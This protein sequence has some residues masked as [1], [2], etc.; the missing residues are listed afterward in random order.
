MKGSIVSNDVAS[1]YPFFNIAGIGKVGESGVDFG[2]FPVPGSGI[3]TTL[4]Q[5]MLDL[6]VDLGYIVKN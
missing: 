4:N 3:S 6:F 2:L 1:Q 5:D